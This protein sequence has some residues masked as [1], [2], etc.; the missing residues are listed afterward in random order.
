M[1]VTYVSDDVLIMLWKLAEK[2][3]QP[4]HGLVPP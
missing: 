3:D 4:G 1:I 2:K